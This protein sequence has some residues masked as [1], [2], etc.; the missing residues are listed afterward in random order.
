[1]RLG[2][3]LGAVALALFVTVTLS[4]SVAWAHSGFE[5]HSVRAGDVAD[6]VLSLENERTDA[7]TVKLDLRFPEGQPLIVVAVPAAAG[8]TATV[9]GGAIGSEATGIV[10]ERPTAGPDDDPAVT[11][12][13]GPI[14]SGA[15]QLQF[16]VLQ[17]YSNG[18]IDR[19]IDDWPAGQPEP[20]APGPVLEVTPGAAT[21]TPPT[22]IA[23]ATT[24]ATTAPAATTTTA[25]PTPSDDD[26][27]SNTG[28][29][30][31][32]IVIVV[33][34]GGGAAAWAIRRRRSA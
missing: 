31:A 32:A 27:D 16:K 19:W 8:W 4:A 1:M 15:E 18:E 13:L 17:T 10:W 33:L 24:T 2:R 34:L 28:L 5:P 14:P 7:G 23:P 3:W 20:D 22:T 9:Q 21:T 30:V 11:M 12:R 25:A 6:L 29:I 26:D